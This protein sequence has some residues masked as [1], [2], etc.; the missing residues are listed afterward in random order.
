MCNVSHTIVAVLAAFFLSSASVLMAQKKIKV[1]YVAGTESGDKEDVSMVADGRCWTKWC[2]SDAKKLPYYVILDAQKT[3]DVVRYGLVTGEDTGTYPGRNPITW[4]VYGSN[5]QDKWT[6]LDNIKFDQR[7][8]AENEKE[9]CYDIKEPKTFR[10]YK[11]EFVR[12][13]SGTMIQLSE[14][15]LYSK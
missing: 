8:G 11:F 7:M 12:M 13:T 5:D 14:I 4:K 10:Y 9:Y 2:M 6:L 15:N 1:S 3:T